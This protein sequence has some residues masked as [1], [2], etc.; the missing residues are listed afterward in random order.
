VPRTRTE[1]G[2]LQALVRP[3]SAGTSTLREVPSFAWRT[4]GMRNWQTG[5]A[6][7][8]ILNLIITPVLEKCALI[9]IGGAVVRHVN[10]PANN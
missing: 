2:R 5:E 8:K 10:E 7:D 9:T 3:Y 4:N 1:G 6:A